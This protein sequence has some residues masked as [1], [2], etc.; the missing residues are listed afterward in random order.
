MRLEKDGV[1]SCSVKN[2]SLKKEREI[3]AFLQKIA[4]SFLLHISVT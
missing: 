1:K 3:S 2:I 4:L